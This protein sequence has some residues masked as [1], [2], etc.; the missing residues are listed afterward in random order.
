MDDLYNAYYCT[1]TGQD[2]DGFLH[3]IVKLIAAKNDNEAK[4]KA[5][6]KSGLSYIFSVTIKCVDFTKTENE[7]IEKYNGKGE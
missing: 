3:N 2:S 4:E 6:M 1:I 7:L 5:K